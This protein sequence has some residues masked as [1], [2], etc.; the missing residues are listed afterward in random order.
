M[1][2]FLILT[3]SHLVKL[4]VL[5]IR[6]GDI[7][8][9]GG[10]QLLLYCVLNFFYRKVL[11][12]FFNL[13]CDFFSHRVCNVRRVIIIYERLHHCLNN[14]VLI[15]WHFSAITFDDC[16]SSSPLLNILAALFKVAALYLFD[17][18]AGL[19]L[20]ILHRAV[21]DN[22]II[23]IVLID[24]TVGVVA[25]DWLVTR[26]LN[27]QRQSVKT[28][29]GSLNLLRFTDVHEQHD[30]VVILHSIEFLGQ[31]LKRRVGILR[32]QVFQVRQELSGLVVLLTVPTKPSSDFLDDIYRADLCDQHIVEIS[33][34][35][36]QRTK[37]VL[38]ASRWPIYNDDM[39]QL[40]LPS[41]GSSDVRMS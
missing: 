35:S 28:F 21:V 26:S 9:L 33:P 22:R 16:H 31:I 12:G 38:S 6:L 39:C 25:L 20:Q 13:V 29:L 32:R 3:S 17:E 10:H 36:A 14:F 40:I 1:H 19:L 27:Q 30:V 8:I 23:V 11:T 15:K 5:D 41:G 4:S 37:C 7:L 2:Q 24:I 34:V 18:I